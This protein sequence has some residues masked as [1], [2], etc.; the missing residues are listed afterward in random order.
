MTI[1]K[2]QGQTLQRVGLHLQKEVFAHGQL[3]VA[4]SRVGSIDCLSVFLGETK[5]DDGN[6][7]S[8][9]ASKNIVYQE[10]LS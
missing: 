3:Y 10:V 8:R 2:S 9:T 4:L 6:T 1:N 7:E 5:T